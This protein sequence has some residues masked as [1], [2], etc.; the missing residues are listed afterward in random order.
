[1]DSILDA[2]QEGRLIELPDND[3][4]DALKVLSHILEAIPSIPTGTD[5]VGMVMSREISTNTSLGK[6]WA[7][8]HARVS[9]EEDLMCVIGWS[10]VGIDYG[11]T[12][13]I[14]VSIIIMHMVPPNQR[15]QYLR[16]IS[17][18]AKAL[19]SYPDL[20]KLRSAR[21]LNDIR[22]YLL[23]LISATK[24]TVGPDTRARM[25][26]LQARPSI[27]TMPVP[28]LSNLVVEPLTLIAVPGQKPIV[29]AQNVNL[30]ESLESAIDLIENISSRGTYQK[31]GWRV[32]KREAVTYQGDR[33]AYDCLAI[34]TRHK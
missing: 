23:D 24:E 28:D 14:P 33:V 2:L 26:Q 1:M 32:I 15:N 11:A 6:G 3:K 27:E 16:E 7:C 10:P 21:E 5:V 29:L 31:G 18:L 25:I 22:D 30:V 4:N 20:E 12:D 8:P 34:K 19:Q 17:L 9:F 13:G